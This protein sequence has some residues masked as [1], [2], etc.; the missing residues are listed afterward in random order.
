VGLVNKII[1]FSAA[2]DSSVCIFENGK[3]LNFLKEERV[4]KKKRDLYPIKSLYQLDYQNEKVDLAYST[5][6]Q[7]SNTYNATRHFVQKAF[8]LDNSFDYSDEHHLVHANLAFYDS[9]FSEALV[10]VIDRNGS[11][12]GQS[13]RESETVYIA[14]YPNNF[15]Q[16][17]KNF[18]VFDNSAHEYVSKLKKENPDCEFNASSMF[19]IVKVYETATMLI[20]QHVLENGK[21]MGLSAYGDKTKIYPDLFVNGHVPNDYY[22]GHTNFQDFRAAT[23]TA[24]E[25]ISTD[26]INENNYQEYADYAWN[27][28]KQTQEAVASMINKYVQKTGIKNVCITGGYGLNVVANHY[29]ITQFPDIN[30][31]FEPLADDSGNSI[32][33]AMKCYRDT[34]LDTTINKLEHTFFNGKKYK[35]NDIDGQDVSVEDVAKLLSNGKSVAVYNGIAEAG[36]RSL[37]NR[38]ILFD[39]RDK[40]SKDKVNKIKKRE[41]YRPFAGMVLE[42]EANKY[43]EMGQINKS[44]FMTVSFPVKK[45]ALEII[46]GVVHID[47]T[48]R[49]Q[50]VNQDNPIMFNLLNEFKK[51]TGIGIL[52]NTSFNLAGMPLVETPEDAIYTLKNSVL[53]YVWFPEI[54]KLVSKENF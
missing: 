26:N 8:N 33:S 51:I 10:F 30:F 17:Y 50:T 31:F 53:D 24:L 20:K 7:D 13:M 14:S 49:I 41:W 38:S 48:C 6:T 45:S 21:T 2:H 44:E 54:S 46:P 4:T 34:T 42:S 27:I 12:V 29:Y 40:N 32:G 16:I 36:P 52:L 11:I 9:G 3:V 25:N 39:C 28:Q 35:I 43:F 47:E 37:G 19:G 15:K 23:Y 1:G 5:P 22:F 18:W